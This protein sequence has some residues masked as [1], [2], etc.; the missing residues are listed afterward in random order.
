MRTLIVSL[1]L[2]AVAAAPAYALAVTHA[3][4]NGAA[5]VAAANAAG[6]TTTGTTATTNG[7]PSTAVGSQPLQTAPASQ[8]T[9]GTSTVASGGATT[10]F[11]TN[12]STDINAATP[13]DAFAP[14][15]AFNPGPGVATVVPEGNVSVIGGTTGSGMVAVPL[16]QA[17]P[18]QQ[19]TISGS[20]QTPLFD[21][22]AREGRAKEARRRA[23]GE[24]PRVYGIAPNTERDLTWQMPDDRIIRY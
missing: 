12:Q 3:S 10:A 13:G 16:A 5:A 20:T 15:G 8:N 14:G 7:V 19:V 24:E 4:D 11:G 2:A 23:R 9:T 17:Q 1:G 18:S 22:A 21:Q 6:T